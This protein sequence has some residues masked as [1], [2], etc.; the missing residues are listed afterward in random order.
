VSPANSLN[1]L[2]IFFVNACWRVL[3]VAQPCSLLMNTSMSTRD[4]RTTSL[5]CGFYRH[6]S[7]TVQK[8]DSV[9]LKS[10]SGNRG[11]VSIQSRLRAL[12]AAPGSGP[13]SA[14]AFP[15]REAAP[16]AKL[17]AKIMNLDLQDLFALA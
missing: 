7:L 2:L 12:A 17:M 10:S 1:L 15:L 4:K 9:R 5:L 16:L 8:P 11:G 14:V 6:M 13:E 3:R